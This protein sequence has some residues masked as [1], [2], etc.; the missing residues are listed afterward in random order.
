ML[1]GCWPSIGDKCADM[2]V[3]HGDVYSK[4]REAERLELR[5]IKRNKEGPNVFTEL[6]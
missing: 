3:I 4:L 2:T 5:G 6:Y 1:Q